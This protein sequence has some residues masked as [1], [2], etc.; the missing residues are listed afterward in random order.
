[1][2]QPNSS[3]DQ[4]VL[5]YYYIYI[6]YFIMFIISLLHKVNTFPFQM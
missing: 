1:M 3:Q 5:I 4:D 6:S 2:S